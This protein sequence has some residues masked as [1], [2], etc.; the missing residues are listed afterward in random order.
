MARLRCV[1]P[2]EYSKLRDQAV[3]DYFS[4]L[5]KKYDIMP[6][7]QGIEL[8]EANPYEYNEDFFAFSH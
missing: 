8:L 3:R 4:D 1:S 6:N 2:I 5:R 7:T